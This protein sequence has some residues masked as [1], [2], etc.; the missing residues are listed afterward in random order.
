[1]WQVPKALLPSHLRSWLYPN[2]SI[3]EKTEAM[4]RRVPSILHIS[5]KPLT[6]FSVS[7]AGYLCPSSHSSLAACSSLSGWVLAMP[8]VATQITTKLCY[9]PTFVAL[10]WSA[11]KI[12][13]TRQNAKP[14]SPYRYKKRGGQHIKLRNFWH[15]ECLLGDSLRVK[16]LGLNPGSAI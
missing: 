16:D 3:T 6:H 9:V 1:M 4:P 11:G 15:V 5:L 2:V 10:Q 7:K 12:Q 13:P 14:P 8:G